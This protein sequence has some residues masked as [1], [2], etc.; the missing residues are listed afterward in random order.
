MNLLELEK[1]SLYEAN[2]NGFHLEIASGEAVVLFGRDGTGKNAVLKIAAGIFENHGGVVAWSPAAR[3]L[4]MPLAYLPSTGG[5]IE[6][7]TLLQNVSLPVM[8]HELMTPDE[9][10]LSAQKILEEYGLESAAG[11][12]PADVD[13]VTRRLS[14]FARA[15][16]ISPLLY[17]IEEPLADMDSSAIQAIDQRLNEIKE[18]SDSA[19]LLSTGEVGPYLDWGDR[20]V[21]LSPGR[22]KTFSSRKELLDSE[23]P[24]V[25][26]FL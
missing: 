8:Y 15:D 22:F 2:I 3:K 11:L 25:R 16:L 5:L 6:N 23:D 18:R 14:L 26:V 17:I 24:E 1:L 19:V 13:E 10:R 4:P 9:A 20:F 7:M 21:F 12:L